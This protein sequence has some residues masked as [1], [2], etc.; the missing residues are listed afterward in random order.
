[1]S[2]KR[3]CLGTL[4]LAAVGAL[5][6]HAQETQPGA[7]LLPQ[8]RQVPARAEMSPPL[9][10]PVTVDPYRLPPPAPPGGEPPAPHESG[11]LSSW[12]AYPQVDCCGPMGRD[13]PIMVELFLRNGVELP[14]EGAIFGHVLQPG[15]IIEGGGRSIF[16]NSALDAAWDVDL[17]IANV[18]NRGQHSDR[19][20]LI[21]QPVSTGTN[22]IT[23]QPL[24]ITTRTVE[25]SLRELNRTYVDLGLGHEWYFWG[26]KCCPGLRWRAGIDAGG[27]LGTQKAE[28]YEIQHR[29]DVLAGLFVGLHS[30]VEIPCGGCCTFIAG[31]R[32][33]WS[34]NWSDILQAH[35]DSDLQDVDFTVNLGVRF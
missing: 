18:F 16:F 14:V 8:P 21:T 1:M 25:T 13:G 10:A 33:E 30:D 24:G 32:A 9:I 17:S 35:N 34:Y 2:L 20:I 6:I 28:F 12:M 31:L 7:D 27:R 23:G 26:C 15:W 29:T 4:V 22:P 3:T 19:K 5:P 11:K